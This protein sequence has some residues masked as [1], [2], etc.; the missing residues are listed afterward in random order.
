MNCIMKHDP[1]SVYKAVNNTF[2][3]LD[4]INKKF[5]KNVF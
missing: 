1:T 3:I 5:L 4:Y 2:N